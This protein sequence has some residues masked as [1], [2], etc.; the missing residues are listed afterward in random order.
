M[1]QGI[2]FG[3]S[4]TTLMVIALVF[5]LLL[6]LGACLIGPHNKLPGRGNA[7]LPMKSLG[8]SPILQI[9]LA[10]RDSD[11]EAVLAAGDVK[12][13][14]QDARIGNQLDTYLFIPAYAALLVT[15]G[16]L[17]IQG[18]SGWQGGLVWFAL[19]AVLVAAACDWRENA[20]ITATL[21]HFHRAGKPDARDALH[22]SRPSFVKWTLLSIILLIYGV[23]AATRLAGWRSALSG[24]GLIAAVGMLGGILLICMLIRYV[25]EGGR[26]WA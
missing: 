4:D 11:L 10:R 9:E 17:L 24:M 16:L 20:G 3:V 1:Q 15:V 14:L 23:S 22:I 26:P 7:D 19:L 12:R 5:F 13:N 6:L 2:R 18:S 25:M 8:H 21:D